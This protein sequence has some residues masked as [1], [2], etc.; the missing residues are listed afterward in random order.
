[1]GS[2]IRCPSCGVRKY[3]TGEKRCENCGY[4]PPGRQAYEN[5]PSRWRT[6][7]PAE[8]PGGATG[9]MRE[10]EAYPEGA[11]LCPR[12]KYRAM[13]WDRE[14]ELYTCLRCDARLTKREFESSRR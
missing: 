4:S 12:C 8:E 5:V 11:E 13:V 14:I 3:D 7:W 6:F 2:Y 9:V 1:M 10:E